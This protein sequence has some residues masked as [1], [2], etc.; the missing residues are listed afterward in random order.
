[1]GKITISNLALVGLGA[2]FGG[3]YWI[4][5]T[6]FNFYALGLLILGILLLLPDI[7]KYIRR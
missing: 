5:S 4:S 3:L 2:I 6:A 7:I 1:M